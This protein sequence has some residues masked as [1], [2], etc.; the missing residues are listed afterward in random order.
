MNIYF[1][2]YFFIFLFLFFSSI[3]HVLTLSNLKILLFFLGTHHQVVTNTYQRTVAPA[4][5]K[6]LY[7]IFVCC[8]EYHQKYLYHCHLLHYCFLLFFFFSF[9]SPLFLPF[10]PPFFHLFFRAHGATSALND[11]YQMQRK[12]AFPHV[13]MA[14]QMLVN[15]MPPPKD[16]TQGAGGCLGGDPAEVG[17]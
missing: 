14:P 13:F 6:G 1:F 3:K 4:G 16:T 5:K 2:F 15:C 7:I 8:S 17:P 10:S 9:F 11:R 12:N